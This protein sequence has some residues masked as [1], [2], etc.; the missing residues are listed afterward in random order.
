MNECDVGD[1]D[2][3][4]ALARAGLRSS[5]SMWGYDDGEEE[6]EEAEVEARMTAGRGK[7]GQRGKA[8]PLSSPTALSLEL[9]GS[10]QAEVREVK[11]LGILVKEGSRS[12]A[13]GITWGSLPAHTYSGSG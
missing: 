2:G 9:P 6:E 5:R 3:I 4:A 11:G 8:S 13:D 1:L 7:D 10:L 12:G